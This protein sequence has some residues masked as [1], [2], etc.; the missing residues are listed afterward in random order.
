MRH[1]TL[2]ILILTLTGC[3][4]ISN[5]I[6]Q[7]FHTNGPE[8]M[9]TTTCQ[10]VTQD[11]SALLYVNEYSD[12]NVT[13]TAQMQMMGLEKFYTIPLNDAPNLYYIYEDYSHALQSDV[14]QGDDTV[15]KHKFFN[16]Q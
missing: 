7:D 14:L 11:Y 5:T 1:L 6:T 2:T 12:G 16:Y 10:W 8:L 4:K 13:K 3:G 15:C 9:E